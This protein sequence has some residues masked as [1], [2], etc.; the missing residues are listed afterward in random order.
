[1]NSEITVWQAP[2]TDVVPAS[3]KTATEIVSYATQLNKKDVQHIIAAFQASSYEMVSGFVLRKS[4]SALKKQLSALGMGFIGEMLARPDI[5]ENSSANSV[6]T[7][8]EAINLGRELGIISTTDAKRLSQAIEMLAHFDNLSPEES[9]E[10]DFTAEE[11]TLYLRTCV[12][13]V[14]GKASSEPSLSFVTFR[15]QLEERTF[16][17]LDGE[18]VQLAQSPYFFKRTALSVLLSGIKAKSGAQ[19]EHLVGNSAVIIPVL[20]ESLKSQERWSV[21]QTYAEVVSAGLSAAAKGIKTALLA[22]KGFDYVPESLRSST[23]T[24]AANAVLTAHS[25]FQNFYN[26][27]AAI[28]ALARLGTTIPWPAFANCMTAIFAIALGNPYGVSW[29]AQPD[30]NSL[31]DRLSNNQWDY[32]L[33][34]CLPR[35]RLILGKLCWD[36]PRE[37]WSNLVKKYELGESNVK[38]IHVKRLLS[39]TEAGKADEIKR[40]AEGL[41]SSAP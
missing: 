13:A 33:N 32:F 31:L 26:E 16:K 15:A 1:M 27:P 6:I 11:A 9:D 34:E 12:Q 8:F 21:G 28:Q 18:I 20:W 29:A 38:N 40:R 37:N 7:D 3:A 23:F 41:L 2:Q 10:V 5:T 36:K 19:F 4:L 22:V 24:A 35:D 14:L 25:G 39:E 30:A 17:A